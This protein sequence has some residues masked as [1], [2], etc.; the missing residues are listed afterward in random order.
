[1]GELEGNSGE[2]DVE[3]RPAFLA[4]FAFRSVTFVRSEWFYHIPP[5][6]S[7]SSCRLLPLLPW[8][9]LLVCA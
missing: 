6:S 8:L 7:S 4:R 2:V 9:L 5:F 3:S 1:M